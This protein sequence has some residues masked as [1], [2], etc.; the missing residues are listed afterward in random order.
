[1]I[2]VRIEHEVTS[3]DG[4]KKAFDSDPIERKKSGVKQYHIYQP[5]DNPKY[6][7]IDLEFESM[8]EAQATKVALEK[9]MTKVI[10]TLIF[11]PKI[12]LL[13]QIESRKY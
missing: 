9:M 7:V 3:Y 4:W 1:M 6:V 11:G 5:A 2:L 12:T 8:S 10:G 13:N